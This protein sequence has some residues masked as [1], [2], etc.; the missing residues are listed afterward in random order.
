MCGSQKAVFCELAAISS[1]LL[2]ISRSG[3]T[4]ANSCRRLEKNENRSSESISQNQ[5][6][7]ISAKSCNRRSDT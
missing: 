1:R 4:P 2:P 6:E 7:A 3:S 5:S